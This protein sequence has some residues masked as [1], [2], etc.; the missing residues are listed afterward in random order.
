MKITIEGD[1]DGIRAVA[2]RMYESDWPDKPWSA[3]TS[4]ER[5]RYRKL[6]QIANAALTS[7]LAAVEAER[8]AYY[9]TLAR[10]TE[11]PCRHPAAFPGTECAS[12]IAGDALHAAELDKALKGE[13][14]ATLS[15]QLAEA[16]GEIERMRA[17]L[18]DCAHALD[19]VRGGD[20]EPKGPTILS[21]LQSV[22]IALSPTPSSE[23][24]S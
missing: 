20:F 16:Q 11:L 21:T 24:K 17:L 15:R 7:R 4:V 2:K 1:R 6:Q 3:A 10:V 23:E 9:K 19:G 5:Y 18:L 22:K 14:A 13:Q 8:D 12:C